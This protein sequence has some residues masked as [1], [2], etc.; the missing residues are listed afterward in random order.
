M[1]ANSIVHYG[2][3][4]PCFL[5]VYELSDMP[6]INIVSNNI[7]FIIV[8]NEHA[9]AVFITDSTIDVLDPLGPTN[10]ETFGPICEFLSNHLPCKLLRMNSKLQ[11]DD[12]KKCALFCLLFLFL[13]CQSYSF[14]DSISFFTCD[15]EGNDETIDDIFNRVFE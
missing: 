11:S 13:R 6:H 15:Y 8:H 10:K 12:S 7:G 3:K 9:M 5:G 1:D 14:H 4:I 2:R